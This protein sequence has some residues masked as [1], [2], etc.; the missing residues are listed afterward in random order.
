MKVI[1]SRGRGK[2]KK[3]NK[4]IFF[5]FFDKI[6]IEW[7][8]MDFD[9][10]VVQP[11]S[12][13]SRF[14]LFLSRLFFFF[15]FLSRFCPN[16]LIS[17]FSRVRLRID[18]IFDDYSEYLFSTRVSNSEPSLPVVE[19]FPTPLA[20][21]RY[22]EVYTTTTRTERIGRRRPIRRREREDVTWR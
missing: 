20:S 7:I 4:I 15:S 14:L 13:V 3:E 11:S 16:N 8:P 10:N 22:R 17:L 21:E 18:S 19:G 2:K 1:H 9:F 12:R 6:R 5:F